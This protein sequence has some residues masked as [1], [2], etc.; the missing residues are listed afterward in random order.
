MHKVKV[1]VGGGDDG[2]VVQSSTSLHLI[3]LIICGIMHENLANSNA[4]RSN[5]N[6]KI[7]SNRVRKRLT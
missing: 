4:V 5:D 6:M 7:Q 1:T 2:G 3:T